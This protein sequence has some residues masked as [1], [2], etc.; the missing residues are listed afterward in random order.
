MNKFRVFRPHR[1]VLTSAV[2]VP[3]LM[4]LMAACG[5]SDRG[6]VSNRGIEYADA[7]RGY[8]FGQRNAPGNRDVDCGYTLGHCNAPGHRDA[9]FGYA[10]SHSNALGYGNAVG[11]CYA[12][13]HPGH[14]GRTEGDWG[15]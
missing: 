3:V 9:D 5:G 2:I 8:A 14:P 4:L 11:Y 1:S 15:V 12:H 7:K 6:G 13:I 10:F